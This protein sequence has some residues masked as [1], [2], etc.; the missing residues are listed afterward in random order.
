MSQKMDRRTFLK[1]AAIGG[2]SF[3]FL[4]DSRLAFAYRQNEKL[5]IAM[6]GA[7]G[8]GRGNLDGVLSENIVAL[9]DVDERLAYSAQQAC[10]K[11]KFFK[12]FRKMLEQMR[13]EIDAV[14]VSTPDHTHAVAAAMAI[15]M[16]KHVYCEK[17]LTRTIWEARMLRD[18]ARRYK[19][20]TQMGNQGTASNELRQGVEVIQS[21]VLGKVTE[22]HVW[23]NRPIWPQGI[24]RPKEEMIIPDGL[25][26][27][28][29]LGPAPKRPYHE[30]YHPFKWRGWID[31]G[32][33][34]IGD[35]ACHTMNM[36]FWALNLRDPI[37]IEAETSGVNGETFPKW[38]I[39][40]Y[41]FPQRGDL[42]PCKMIWY[43]GGQKPPVE[44]LQGEQMADSGLLLIG[45]NGTLY[46]PGDYGTPFVLLPREKFANYQ[47][48]AP[49]IPRSPGHHQEWINACK[50]G[51]AAMSN[52]D[53]ASALTETAL[54]GNLAIIT[55]ERIQ[56]DA[57]RM[58]AVNCPKADKI[59]HP[60]YR[61]GWTL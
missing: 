39:V 49:S 50:G 9:C 31:F 8:R 32:T 22:I 37:S 60:V 58:K 12:D 25:D 52:F 20:A 56:W 41:Q 42:A 6:I 29:W 54:L 7:G 10:P 4:R 45:S 14:V 26:W 61:K 28:L 44:L 15:R 40:R 57:K 17:P 51:P 16:G 47:P 24:D 53:Y 27:E 48:P 55:G 30:A 3:L 35:M 21:G 18:L 1:G 34:A 2:L 46:S 11:A 59:I 23:S 19:V 38:S 36:A 5:N 43:D 13:K 33:G